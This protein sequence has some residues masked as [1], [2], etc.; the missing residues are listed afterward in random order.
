MTFRKICCSISLLL[1]LAAVPVC[2]LSVFAGTS[3]AVATDV[4][5]R[6]SK[7]SAREASLRLPKTVVPVHYDLSFEPDLKNFTFQGKEEIVLNVEAATS[8]V[9]LNAAQLAISDAS[10]AIMSET[11]LRPAKQATGI[12]KKAPGAGT[13]Q[14]VSSIDLDEDREQAKLHFK[15][16]L[17]TGRYVLSC[18]FTGKLNDDLRGF[19]RSAY[20]DSKG[21][22]HYLCATQME[23]TDARRMFPSF[24]EPEFKATYQIS[25]VIE[26]EFTAISNAPIATKE[27]NTNGKAVVKFQTT[28]KMSSYL[29]ALIIGELKPT[30]TRIAAG[31]PITVWTTPGKEQ[32][33]EYA[34]STAVEVLPVEQKYFGILY[35][36]KKLDLIALPDFAWGAMENLGAI[37]FRE[38]LLL[39]DDKTG[40]NF[41]K[42]TVASIE[43]HE[44]AHQWF[45][46]LVT[47]RWWDDL[48]LNEAFATW[49]ATKTIDQIRPEW[50]F[51]AKSV[52]TRNYAMSEDQ[53]QSTR[54]I[55]ADVSNPAQAI[56]MF[57]GITYEKGASI[58]RM[59][60]CF[61]TEKIF[62][63]GI[64][65][66]L[67]RHA[68]GNASTED[69]WKAIA[70]ASNGAINVPD[71]MRPWVYQPGFPLVTLGLQKSGQELKLKQERY[72]EAADARG[73]EALWPI[74]LSFHV[75]GQS[76][77]SRAPALNSSISNSSSN[78]NA[79]SNAASNSG[80]ASRRQKTAGQL[81]AFRHD[82][83]SIDNVQGCFFA[84][85]DGSGFYRVRY[86]QPDFKT[87][88]DKF[89][90]LSAE[91]RLAFLSDVQALAVSGKIEVENPLQLLLKIRQEK[92]LLVLTQIVDYYQSPY[93][94]MNSQSMPA[95]Q[96][97]VCLNLKPLKQRLGWQAKAGEPDLTRDLR[98]AVLRNLGT[99]GQDKETIAEAT[100]LYH[101]YLN[102]FRSVN[103]D[104]VPSILKIVAF[105]GGE[106]EY[107]E[108]H[109]AWRS[110]K[111]PED[112][113]RF[114]QTLAD[115]KHP[116]LVARTLDLL[117]SG[118][119][120]GQDAPGLLAG[121][122]TQYESQNQAWD[123]TRANWSKLLKLFPPMSMR[124]V[125]SACSN[126]Y[127]R[128]DEESLR[129]FFAVHKVPFGESAV[130]RALENVHINV[131]YQESAVARVRQWVVSQ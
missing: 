87:I 98:D 88:S 8:I 74:P 77:S 2:P 12:D 81:L 49:M 58:L 85:K 41:L 128:I 21:R 39:V 68:L 109:A 14:H 118:Q 51:L 11:A 112:E 61:V 130:T 65:D 63:K 57:D 94:L 24:D 105:N 114:L 15:S 19:Y 43:A 129:T 72:F 32:L 125:A 107:E 89:D 53:L 106:K 99:Y 9:V 34:L 55:H 52:D 86:A 100:S 26:P 108:V 25:A 29:V 47:M 66:Y 78:S 102:D 122:L 6:G 111:A 92:D 28:P 37:T 71:V 95:Y 113:K 115:F 131:L 17:K 1:V 20:L 64:H 121:L 90:L 10:I 104:L 7:K 120:R 84:N 31:V 46:D 27:M 73:S 103:P 33:G 30:R 80:E 22:S 82:S 42:R 83:C 127:R 54:A 40:T 116:A 93:P 18:R 67:C 96:K 13:T 76:T 5:S 75:L 110:A 36:G 79:H 70:A 117:L 59:L 119:V 50:R 62:Q 23:P 60:E 35:P 16:S 97:F 91:E 4:P 69:L 38:A 45:G 101:R 123:Y 3:S 48:W 56:E 44:M 124:E 126:F